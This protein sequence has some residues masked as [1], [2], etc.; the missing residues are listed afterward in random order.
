MRKYRTWIIVLL[1]VLLP[2][3][4]AGI[5][6]AIGP[7]HEAK[8]EHDPLSHIGENP[9]Y[10]DLATGEVHM[11]GGES[12]DGELK[13]PFISM[14]Y[15]FFYRVLITWVIIGLILVLAR[16]ATK[17]FSEIPTRTQSIWEMVLGYFDSLTK[18]TLG[19]KGRKY[20][21]LIMSLFIFIVIS[22][23]LGVLPK[24]WQYLGAYV[25]SFVALF[26]SSVHV[27]GDFLDWY[28]EV[29]DGHWLGLISKLPA[30]EEPTADVNTT[31]GCGLIVLFVAH[32]AGIKYAGFKEYFKSTYCEIDV[33]FAKYF[34]V[35]YIPIVALG[36]LGEFGKLISHSFRLFGNI[37]GGS[38]VTL[39]IA[40]LTMR[41]VYLLPAGVVLKTG[42]D[43]ILGLGIGL[44]QA[45][46][47]A[48]LAMVYIAIKI[49]VEE[50][51]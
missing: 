25:G 38:I 29:P 8:Q 18:D 47:F 28:I 11:G 14:R 36:I 33:P 35:I 50:T 30:F 23:W 45:F 44:I 43:A 15:V 27:V 39:V 46:V 41:L 40:S 21:P 26:D 12:A 7:K 51:A 6:A 49:P 19:N 37:L 20:F 22:N 31:L 3:I 9:P 10:I 32:A 13:I 16:K 5:Q 17:R 4:L 1:I 24:V 2:V 48:V 42:F 34:P